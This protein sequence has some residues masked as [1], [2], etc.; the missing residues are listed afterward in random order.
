MESSPRVSLGSLDGSCHEG[1]LR[2]RISRA[3][4]K[5]LSSGSLLAVDR[6][7]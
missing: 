5:F 7:P 6:I 1:F 2:H 3:P 4:S